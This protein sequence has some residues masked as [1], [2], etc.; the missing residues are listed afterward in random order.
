MSDSPVRVVAL[1]RPQS[2]SGVSV[3]GARLSQCMP[4]WTPAIIGPGLTRADLANTPFADI[5][6][7]QVITWP[8]SAS[9]LE[10]VAI[11]LAALRSMGAQVVV[12]NDLPHG[13]LASGLDPSL[14]CAG[15]FQGDHPR[16]HDLYERI[17]PLCH[18]WRG[19]SNSITQTVAL[20]DQRCATHAPPAAPYPMIVLDA[21]TPFTA[22]STLHML[23][24]GWLDG[25]KRPLDLIYLCDALTQRGVDFHLSI[26][27]DGPLQPVLAEGMQSHVQAGR[28]HLLGS[29]PFSEMA[30]LH[31]A[32]DLLIL[33][34]QSEGC[35]L[36]VME[37][38]ATGRPV[39]VSTGCGHAAE[40]ITHTRDGFVFPIGDMSGLADALIPIAS[41]RLELAEMGARIHATACEHFSASV[42][43]PAFASMIQQATS[44][45]VHNPL[46]QFQHWL[47]TLEL[48]DPT[49]REDPAQALAFYAKGHGI[50]PA[51]LSMPSKAMLTP[52]Q[53]LAKAALDS[54]HSDGY[55]RIVLYGAGEHTAHLHCL[56]EANNSVIAILDDRAGEPGGPP[57]SIGNRPVLKPDAIVQ[58]GIDA[59]LLSSDGHEELLAR[60][61]A[62]WAGHRPVIRL[63]HPVNSELEQA[64]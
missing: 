12:P 64:R 54:L 3:A 7:A 30:S 15:L 62:Q 10:Q 58:L 5:D 46:E 24:A 26:A 23:Y 17:V 2:L 37:A 4:R 44:T 13:Y 43:A 63:Y 1:H 9:P 45:T 31:Q 42:C 27:G 57:D 29:V 33:T 51:D 48:L 11:V 21:P 28:A 18:A 61:A 60:R 47:R 52:R 39:A 8:D 53:R 25:N 49:T 16:D 14:R 55:T 34:S 36:V 50:N 6:H 59:I 38:M 35:P 19:V 22:R 41:D 32:N 56:I 40:I 20:H